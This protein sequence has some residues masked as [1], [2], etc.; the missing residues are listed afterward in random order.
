MTSLTHTVA[1]PVHAA[2]SR[3]DIRRI[4][5]DRRHTLLTEI[6]SAIRE[7]RD[8]GSGRAHQLSDIDDILDCDPEDDVAFAIVH[9][10]TQML[11]KI[12]EAVYN[13]E[14]GAYGQCMD[15][16]GPISAAR[17]RALPFAVRC[18]DCEERREH[19]AARHGSQST[20][21]M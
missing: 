17:L 18:R 12:D 3:E 8:E 6:Q 15:C 16:H 10:R 13:L 9:W 14:T 19:S 7:I 5:M 11:H 21:G 20:R 2:P 1:P 4:L